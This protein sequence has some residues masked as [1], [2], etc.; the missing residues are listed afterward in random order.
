AKAMRRDRTS[1]TRRGSRLR[2][3][4]GD[5]AAF[6]QRTTAMGGAGSMTTPSAPQYGHASIASPVY[7]WPAASHTSRSYARSHVMWASPRSV[8]SVTVFQASS[9]SWVSTPGPRAISTLARGPSQSLRSVAM[10]LSTNSFSCMSLLAWSSS[11]LLF[12]GVA[13]R[14]GRA[15]LPFGDCRRPVG[16]WPWQ[17]PTIGEGRWWTDGASSSLAHC[18]HRDRGDRP[19]PRRLVR[20]V[21]VRHLPADVSHRRRRRSR[22][23]DDPVGGGV[24]RDAG[25]P[26]GRHPLGV[27]LHRRDGGPA[28]LR[29]PV[30]GGRRPPGG[31][32]RGRRP[33]PAAR[34]GLRSRHQGGHLP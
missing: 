16:G 24:G 27:P 13:G 22:R 26:G 15:E 10:A 25:R 9:A 23:R 12:Y 18:R 14:I 20:R 11:S 21:V 31:P 30:A 3:A 5:Q 28:L 4:T 17:P 29:L 34:S 2:H 8:P 7:S 19:F 1:Q 32:R 33:A 6:S